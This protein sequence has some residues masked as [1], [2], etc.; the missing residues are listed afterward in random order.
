MTG[1]VDIATVSALQAAVT[2][3][4]SDTSQ[5]RVVLDLGAVTFMDSTGVKSVVSMDRQLRAQDRELLVL[6]GPSPVR[7][8]FEVM[9]ILDR[10]GFDGLAWR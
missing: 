9:G 3:V 8:I 1:E 5:P 6:P 4:V 10:P 7:R 2:E